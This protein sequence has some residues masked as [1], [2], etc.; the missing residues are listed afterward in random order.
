MDYILGI[1]LEY[2]I[3]EICQDVL[4]MLYKNCA[5]RIYYKLTSNKP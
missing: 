2:R 5:T 4:V 3:V 1:K